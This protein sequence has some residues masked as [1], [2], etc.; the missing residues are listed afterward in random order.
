MLWLMLASL[1]MAGPEVASSTGAEVR[2][3]TP[4]SVD[5]SFEFD[6][7]ASP[8]QVSSGQLVVVKVEPELARPRQTLMPVLYAG[9]WPVQVLTT[10][11]DARCLVGVVPA[12]VD[13]SKLPV[14]F[15]GEALPER[16]RRQDGERELAAALASRHPAVSVSPGEAV[17]VGSLSELVDL[18]SGKCSVRAGNSN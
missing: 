5:Q 7:T 18:A 13:L 9:S 16:I 17:H 2:S 8:F 14:F 3:I 12:S 6:F 10:A 4:F 11:A 15:G 1:A